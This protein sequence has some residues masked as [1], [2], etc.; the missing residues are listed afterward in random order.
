MIWM[1]IAE[2]LPEACENASP[3]NIG[4]VLTGGVVLMM[5]LQFLGV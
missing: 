2:V 4:I 5:A 1:V 3:Y